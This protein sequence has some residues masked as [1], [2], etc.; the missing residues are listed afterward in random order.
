MIQ[1]A[2]ELGVERARQFQAHLALLSSNAKIPEYRQL[3]DNLFDLLSDARIGW[4]S[5]EAALIA[6]QKKIEREEGNRIPTGC[7]RVYIGG[8]GWEQ[9][10]ATSVNEINGW[11]KIFDKDDVCIQM[12]APGKWDSYQWKRRPNEKP[13][14]V[15]TPSPVIEGEDDATA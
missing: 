1:T 12:H 14:P 11:L 13:E 5:K 6:A 4:A 2:E 8:G 15:E 7:C 3:I 10:D 9:I